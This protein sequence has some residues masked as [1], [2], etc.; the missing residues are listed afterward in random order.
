MKSLADYEQKIDRLHDDCP[1]RAAIDVIRGRWKP[2]LLFELKTGPRRFSELQA[3]LTGIT[4]QALTVQLRQLEADGI[5]RRTLYPETPPRVEYEVTQYGASLSAVM[6][7]LEAW[8]VAYLA[9][10]AQP[11]RVKRP[12]SVR[13]RL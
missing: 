4:A 12:A 8:G 11:A 1:V 9:R 13:V 10:R 3:A 5:I 7:Q 6:D 2:S